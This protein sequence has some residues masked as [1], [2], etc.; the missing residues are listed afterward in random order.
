MK[1]QVDKLPPAVAAQAS[2]VNSSL[3][4]G[5]AG[6]RLEAFAA[7][8]VKLLLAAPERL[9]QRAFVTALASAR[10]GLVVVD[11]VHCVSMWGHDFRPGLPVHP[12]GA[13]RARRPA[14]ARADGDR[15]A[16]H[17]G[18]DRPR[19]RA[20]VRRSC[21]RASSGRTS[22]TRSTRST[23]EEDRRRQLLDRLRE[24]DG[25]AIVYARSRKKCEELARLLRGHGVRAEHYHAGLESAERTRVQ[26]AF[27]G[28]EVPV[29]VATTAFGMGIDK[30]DIRLV[31]LYNLPGSLE[32]YVQMVGRAGRDGATSRCVLFAGRRDAGDLRRFARS[33]RADARRP[34]RRSTG[35]CATRAVGGVARVAAEE[36]SDERRRPRARRHARAGRRSSAA[37]STPAARSRSSCCRR[38][39]DAAERIAD[40][41]ARAERQALERVD[42]IVRYGESHAL[43]AGR[44]R[45]ALRRGGRAPSAARATAAPRR[46]AVGV[47][48]FE[49]DAAE[50]AGGRRGAILAR[51][52]GPALAA[53]RR[54]ARRDALRLRLG[55]A[56]GAALARVRPARGRDAVRR[57]SAGSGCS[58]ASGHLE[59]YESDDGYPAPPRR[60]GRR[61]AAA[62]R[63]R[64]APRRPS[65]PPRRRR[66]GALRAAAR[67]AARDGRG[68]RR[69]RVRRPPRQDAAGARGRPA[70][71]RRSSWRT[72]P[73]SARRSS[74]ATARP[75]SG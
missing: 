56:V 40:L 30:P 60:A 19:A 33:R 1:D 12:G 6:R 29:V 22:A 63:R 26:E 64:A 65:A 10:V 38:R 39:A 52:G 62:D 3:G 58:S 74:S 67:V 23:S 2:V 11:E 31:L 73:G 15:D 13:R 53:R 37:A 43:P 25:P 44:D 18:R 55:A 70:G 28:D 71:R 75:C 7:G 4:P 57:S 16:R 54:R 21:A 8:G 45:R 66:R 17:G 35:G 46:R 42:R 59:R 34:A 24:A 61:A 14:G 50:P 20:A 47:V 9:R 27:V 49:D 69:A 72:S 32:D 5:E 68:R 41:L 51:G 48:A 36:L